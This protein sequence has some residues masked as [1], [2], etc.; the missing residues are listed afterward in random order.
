VS[1]NLVSTLWL[2]GHLSDPN[3]LIL[4]ASWHLPAAK[5]N[6]QDEFLAGHIAGAV[7]FDLDASSDPNSTLP[8][9]LPSTEKFASDMKRLGASDS[10]HII[11]YDSVGL[12]SAARLWW[13]LKWFGHDRVSVLDGG[14]LKWKAED[15]PLQSGEATKPEARHFTPHIKPEIVRTQSD[16]AAALADKS[17]QLVD[18]RSPSRFRGEEPEPR[19]GVKP[20]H[21][22]GAYNVHYTSLININ[23]TLKRKADLKAA[24]EAAGINFDNPV[25]TTCGSGV[26]A[27]ILFLALAEL[28]HDKTSLYDGSWAEWGASGQEIVTN[29]R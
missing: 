15:H 3:V 2:A 4:D 23:G 14:L 11:C 13:M 17:A 25:I 18:A 21:M 20:G 19:P 29:E 8:Q 24:F 10:K 26:T 9:M 1:S 27:A 16:V 7:F 6:A 22:P 28:G 12:F 5:R